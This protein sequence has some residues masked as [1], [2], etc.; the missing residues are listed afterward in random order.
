MIKFESFYGQ[1]REEE[2][3]SFIEREGIKESQ[4]KNITI[5]GFA[6]VLIYCAE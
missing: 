6:L 5:D 1:N 4:I 2:L 3:N